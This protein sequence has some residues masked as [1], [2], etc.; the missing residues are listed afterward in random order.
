MVTGVGI[1]IALKPNAALS[2]GKRSPCTW[3]VVFSGCP[4][5]PSTS[6]SLLALLPR[7]APTPADQLPL[8]LCEQCS[9][10]L[11]SAR[12]DGEK[13]HWPVVSDFG[14]HGCWA[15]ATG[16]VRW[17]GDDGAEANIT[18]HESSGVS[19]CFSGFPR[20]NECVCVNVTVL[21]QGSSWWGGNE[22]MAP[23]SPPPPSVLRIV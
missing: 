20:L 19:S 16:S 22:D 5:S 10:L 3:E 15:P 4:R 21:P 6:H 13:N 9:F 12:R 1:C 7:P 8:P 23:L 2:Q 18:V 14:S 11:T 17:N